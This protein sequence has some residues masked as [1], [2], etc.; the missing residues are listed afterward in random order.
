MAQEAIR[1]VGTGLAQ[2]VFGDRI[3]ADRGD[4]VAQSNDGARRFGRRA[5]SLVVEPHAGIDLAARP[6]GP[7]GQA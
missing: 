5:R 6:F 7:D 1:T 4:T 3:A 2:S